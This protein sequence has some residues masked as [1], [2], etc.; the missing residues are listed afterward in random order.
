[1]VFQLTPFDQ[2]V[3]VLEMW[4]DISIDYDPVLFKT[5]VLTVRFGQHETLENVLLVLSRATGSNYSVT[6]EEIKITKNN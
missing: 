3:N 4:Y 1:M 5:D 6:N 2:V